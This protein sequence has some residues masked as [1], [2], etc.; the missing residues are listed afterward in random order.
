MYSVENAL[1]YAQAQRQPFLE[2]L[3][4]LLRI[5][6]ISTLPQHAPDMDRAAAWLAARLTAI[7]LNGVELLPT[8][9]YPVVYGEWLGAGPKAPTLLVYGHYDVQPVDPLDEW[10]TPPF[11]PTLIGD[12]LFC[13]GASD[14]KGQAFAILAAAE[15]Y[16]ATGGGLP[17]NLKVMLEGEEEVSSPHMPAFVAD[18]RA[19]LAADAVLI[20][21]GAILG[22][23]SPLISY[24]VRG[25]HGDGSMRP[26]PRL[27]FGHLRRRSG[28]PLQC[29]GAHPGWH[30][31][32][33][34][35][36]CARPRLL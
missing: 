7:G 35:P 17:I 29:V 24:G 19:R 21:D 12:K 36:P 14:D 28:Q 30:T 16:L 1:A 26:G 2:A 34:F 31:G 6:S 20:S 32:W 9:G 4:D 25:P 10:Q 8:A 11:E 22:P 23:Q 3:C 33:R 27:A 15:S 13:R 18:Q 5:P